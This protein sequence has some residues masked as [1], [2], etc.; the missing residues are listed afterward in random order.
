MNEILVNIIGAIVTLVLIPLIGLG[1]KALINLIA[2]KVKSEKLK[3]ALTSATEL[4]L[5]S[6]EMVAQ[7]FV[8]ELKTAGTFDADKQKE[9]FSKALENAK[10]LMS[11]EVKETVTSAYSDLDKWLATLIEAY[12]QE[13]KT[14]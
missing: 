11:D 5:R 13:V 2:E 1:G 10:G 8:D 9:A 4:A 14:K 3:R 7:T 12:I 6:V